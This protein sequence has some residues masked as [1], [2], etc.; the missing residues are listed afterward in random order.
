MTKL[1]AVLPAV[2]TFVV[3]LALCAVLFA[4]LDVEFVYLIGPAIAVA[5]GAFGAYG[6]CRVGP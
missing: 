2:A 5:A 4:A 6:S 3:G 1:G